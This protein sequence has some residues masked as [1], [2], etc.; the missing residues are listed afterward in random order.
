MRMLLDRWTNAAQGAKQA[1]TTTYNNNSEKRAANSGA[2]P[3][4][5]ARGQKQQQYTSDCGKKV[6]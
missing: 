2:Q 5:V 1:S 3:R 6:F 4:P